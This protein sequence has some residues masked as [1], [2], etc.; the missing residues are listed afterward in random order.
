M[1]VACSLW[2]RPRPGGLLH[3]E[4]RVSVHAGLPTH[5]RHPLQWLRGLCGGRSGHRPGQDLP[6][7]L[8]RLHHLQVRVTLDEL[9]DWKPDVFSIL[10]PARNSGG[11]IGGGDCRFISSGDSGPGNKCGTVSY[12]M[13]LFIL[14]LLATNLVINYQFKF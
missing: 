4:W 2:L 13:R 7:R 1:F 9:K 6:P 14:L 10:S 11:F 5:A 3:E 8:L 12:S